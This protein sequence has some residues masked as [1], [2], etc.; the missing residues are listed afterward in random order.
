M[1]ANDNSTPDTASIVYWQSCLV[2]VQNMVKRHKKLKNYTPLHKG[3]S[4]VVDTRVSAVQDRS[5]AC[6]DR[7]TNKR[8]KYHVRQISERVKVKVEKL[9]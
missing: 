3:S 9:V 5:F 4:G 1:L 6:Q 8:V 2:E 7:G